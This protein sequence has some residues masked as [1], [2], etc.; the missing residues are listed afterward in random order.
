LTPRSRFYHR[1]AQIKLEPDDLGRATRQKPANTH[2]EPRNPRTL[3]KGAVRGVWLLG[4]R[5]PPKRQHQQDGHSEEDE[6]DRKHPPVTGL[7]Q[8]LASHVFRALLRAD[9]PEP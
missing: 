9:S 2:A 7:R 3:R 8:L 4:L 1:Q 5:L 6:A